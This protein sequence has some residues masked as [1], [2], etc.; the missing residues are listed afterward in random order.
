MTVADSFIQ[1]NNPHNGFDFDPAFRDWLVEW[2]SVG[3]VV[4]ANKIADE[5]QIG[6]DQ[7]TGKDKFFTSA[8]VGHPTGLL[9]FAAVLR[10]QT[11]RL[12]LP[13]AHQVG[14]MQTNVRASDIRYR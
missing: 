10:G 6:R 3:K 14:R 8:S 5:M 7:I 12:A 11:A 2:N 4:S 9:R 13:A 1:A